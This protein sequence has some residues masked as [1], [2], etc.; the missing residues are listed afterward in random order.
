M[1]E[2]TTATQAPEAAPGAKKIGGWTMAA[3]AA[4][5]APLL[6]LSLPSLIFLAPY[7]NEHLGL[8]LTT[9]S[10]VF[11][12]AR[13]LDIIVDPMIGSFQD[14]STPKM[15]RRRF[16]LAATTPFFMAIIWMVFIGLQPGS[17]PPLVA[18]CVLVMYALFASMTIA[19]LSWAGE[20]LPDYHGRTRTLGAVQVAGMIGYVLMLLLPALV[21]G[22]GGDSVAAVHSMGYAALITLPVL[23]AICVLCVKEE[24]LPPQPHVS[25][26]D[27]VKALLENKSLRFVLVPDFVIGVG[28]GVTG[29]LF[30]FLFRHYL[31]FTANSELLLL[32]Y[33]VSGLIGIPFWTW[34][35]RRIGK[36]RALQWGCIHAGIALALT[37]L[38]PK[39]ELMIGLGAL[40]IAGFSQ[41]AGTMLVRSMMADVVDEDTAK[42]GGQRSGLFF[43]LML[44]TSKVGL[45]VGPLAYVVLDMFGFEQ[46]LGAANTPTAMLALVLLFTGLPFVLNML[47]AWWVRDYPLDERRQ[48]ELRAEIAARS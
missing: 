43:G 29:G 20:L 8:S 35:G 36:H 44:T 4:P 48:A 18:V 32:V 1:A 11:L 34:L 14:R 19:H 21:R 28:Y 9:V 7:F 5:S 39:G 41:S 10:L 38:I 40:V 33:F 25:F 15:G 17:P 6:A 16:W 22:N 2:T 24:K 37:P 23:V 30:L 27:T 47:A 26:R 31:G 46:A 3:F 45:A 42:T 12:S 13:I